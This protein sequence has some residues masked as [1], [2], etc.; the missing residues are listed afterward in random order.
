[1]KGRP[2]DV[3]VAARRDRIA[4]WVHLSGDKWTDA[5]PTL[6]QIS[7]G[8]D[9]PLS[10]VRNDVAAL[11]LNFSREAKG[12]RN[13]DK[14]GA[15]RAARM[16][17]AL[18]LIRDRRRF[19]LTPVP[20]GET[21]VFAPEGAKRTMFPSRVSTPGP[22]PVLKDGCHSSKIGGDVLVG[23]L[24]GA[25]IF[26]LTLEERATCPKTCAHWRSC[27]GNNMQFSDRWKHGAALERR[28]DAEVR[29]LC[30]KHHLVL[31]RLHVLGDFYSFGYLSL[32]ARLLDE[33]PNLHVFGFTAWTPNTKIGGG[34]VRLRDVYPDRFAVRQSGTCGR[35]GAFTIDFPT[36]RNRIGDAVICPEQRDAMSGGKRGIHCGSCGLCWAGNT[37]IA[38]VEH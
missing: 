22:G 29:E 12:R 25:K 16:E 27:Y 32:W 15:K 14:A 4:Q 13:G 11:G 28:L 9:L 6:R 26:T 5:P 17:T 10:V 8:L 19:K 30:A 34:I 36:E 18:E 35:W 37:A 7:D 3:H 31:I 23:R 20:T 21:R 24:K 33:F 2:R 1:M 38:F